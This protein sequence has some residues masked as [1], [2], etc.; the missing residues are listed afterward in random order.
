MI[1][2]LKHYGTVLAEEP[3]SRHTTLRVG[4]TARYLIYPHDVAGVQGIVDFCHEHGI[5]FKIIGKGSNLLVSDRAYNG[6]VIK[7]DRSFNQVKFI[8]QEVVVTSGYSMIKLA[9]ELA[10]RSLT[11]FEW[12]GGVPGNIGGG[13]FMN[14]GAH[15]RELKDNLVRV[16]VM[17]REGETFWLQADECEFAYRTSIFQKHRDWIILEAVLKFETGESTEIKTKMEMWR[18]RRKDTQPL[19]LPNC[20]SVFRNPTPYFAGQL[21]EEL[22]LK[23][24]RIGGAQISEQ[25]ANFIVNV[26]AA[27]A[28]D[29]ADLITLV[30]TQVEQTYGVAM[31]QEVEYFNWS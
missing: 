22:G 8:E 5:T 18:Q 9:N 14:A 29:I 24:K 20:G 25:H 15:G 11:G 26:D 17:N 31:H 2:E 19:Q 16:H 27:T 10:R 6:I 7:L 1:E 3:L 21:I 4:G 13:I 30:Q 23:G 12:A 28:Q